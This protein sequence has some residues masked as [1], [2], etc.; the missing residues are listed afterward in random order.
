MRKIIYL[1]TTL[2]ILI[3]GIPQ[4]FAQT[5]PTILP[6]T[7]D[8]AQKIQSGDIHLSDIPKFIAHFIDFGL[9]IAGSISLL[10]LVIGGYRF[11]IGGVMQSQREQGKQTIL[12]AIIGLV[13]SLL[14]W[15]IVNTIQLLVT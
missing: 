12:Y 14:S 7:E 1:Y 3:A 2:L 6:T 5:T 4:A 10:F 15:A 8:L 9:I 13:L 11:I